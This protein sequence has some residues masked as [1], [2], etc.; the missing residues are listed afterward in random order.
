MT[1]KRTLQ[2][3]D[4]C[5]LRFLN[6][7]AL[8]PDGKR[9]VYAV[10]KINAEEDKEF[11]T[12]YLYDIASGETRQM[13]SGAAV[14]GLPSWSPDGN[15]IAF[16]SDRGGEA[17][18]YLLPADGGEARQLT[19]FQRGIGG[20]IAWSPDGGFIAF[21]AVT[22][23]EAPDLSKEAYRL[24]RTV[25]RFDGI[26]YL[27]DAVQDIYMLD[28]VSG[29]IKQ[30]TDGRGNNSNPRWAPDGGS[31]LYDANMRFDNSRAMTPDL[32]TVDLEGRQTM[33]LEDWASVDKASFTPDGA[34]IVFVGRPDDGKPIGTKSDLYVL[35][36]A[37]GDISCRTQTLDVGVGGRLSLDMPV[38]GL[39]RPNLLVSEDGA[40]AYAT[41]QRG[42]ADHIYRIALQGAEDCRS[43]TQGDCAVFPLD[44]HGEKL[45]YARTSLNSP[46][47]LF[48][49]ELD[50]SASQQLTELNAN[51]IKEIDMPETEHLTWNSIDGVA[52]E[53]WYM[54]PATGKAPYP[55][56]LYIHGGPHAAYGYGFHFDFQMLAGAGYGVLFLNHRASTGYGDGFST[57]IKGDWGNLDYHDLMSG[58]D[59]A[60]ALGLADADRLGVCGTSGGGNLSCWII[61]QTDRF[62]AAIPQN[63]VS[64][65]RSFYGTS[66][67]GIWFSVEQMGGHP[68]EIPDVYERCSPITYAHR[69]RTPT[70]MVQSELDW[71]CPAEQSEQFYTVLKANGCVVEM[72]R[73]PGGYH[74]ASISGAV[75]LR[76]AHND[77]MLEWF[78]R[79][80][81]A[82]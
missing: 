67:I 33:H 10:N 69:C 22:D 57:A 62:K 75:N 45:L 15:S 49:A 36:L 14:D 52:V 30:L 39:S 4:L 80:L 77:A 40:C 2:K 43:L 68:H 60:I 82:V 71:R 81:S 28:I 20:G 61:G 32:K 42:G 19:H 70:L 26:G 50:G 16:S 74:G 79:Y 44:R 37:T 27:D 17:Q 12:I 1:D 65:W 11:S 18:L 25:Y 64:N 73:Q 29:A 63:P 34:R 5:Q 47:D 51:M 35:D 54:K 23:A 7:G 58:V 8:S 31:I 66:D 24:D 48:L 59:H 78:A 72:L 76:R 6:G 55:T 41:V 9:V 53:G 3:E 56:I 21:S 13:T 46:P 38:A